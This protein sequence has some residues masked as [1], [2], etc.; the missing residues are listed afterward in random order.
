MVASWLLW[1]KVLRLD[2][3]ADVDA[4]WR[5]LEPVIGGGNLVVKGTDPHRHVGANGD[6][7]LGGFMARQ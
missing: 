2:F 6:G 3:E 1:V 4:G 5:I 7:L